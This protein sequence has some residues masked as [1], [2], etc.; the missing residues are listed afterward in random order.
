MW[1]HV[2]PELLLTLNRI[3]QDTI[4]SW[5]IVYRPFCIF[6]RVLNW[7]L[8]M[9]RI[10]SG[11]IFAF[12]SVG[13]SHTGSRIQIWDFEKAT[14]PLIRLP[15]QP[16]CSHQVNILMFSCLLL[17]GVT[18]VNFVKVFYGTSNDSS[19]RRLWHFG[20]KPRISS[21]AWTRHHLDSQFSTNLQFLQA[22]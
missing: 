22:G 16:I 3:F 2:N 6:K 12:T 15:L 14:D 7:A 8:T 9:N 11:Y 1:R 5:G 10:N 4:I 17:L 18:I 19:C 21:F 13:C 20:C